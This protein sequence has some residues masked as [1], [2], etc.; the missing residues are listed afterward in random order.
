MVPNLW[1]DLNKN[2]YQGHGSGVMVRNIVQKGTNSCDLVHDM[3]FK[4]VNPLSRLD[5]ILFFVS[6]ICLILNELET[7]IKDMV[8]GFNGVEYCTEGT[9]LMRFGS[10]KNLAIVNPFSRVDYCFFLDFFV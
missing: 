6:T 9:K 2:R 5:F 7:D 8:M 1:L 4:Q 10:K 3:E